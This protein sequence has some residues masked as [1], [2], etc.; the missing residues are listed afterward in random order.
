M[1]KELTLL[2]AFD[3]LHCVAYGMK[4]YDENTI[5]AENI[6]EEA[7]KTL[8]IIKD[9]ADIFFIDD[10]GNPNLTKE[11]KELTKKVLTRS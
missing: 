5:K 7:L 6:I 4:K 1:S 9:K 3:E 10:E 2:E 8:E 11:E